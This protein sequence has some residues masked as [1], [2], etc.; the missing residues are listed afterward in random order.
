MCKLLICAAVAITLLLS[1]RVVSAQDP[2]PGTGT[3]TGSATT[4]DT[5]DTLDCSN[6]PCEVT[7]PRRSVYQ[8]GTNCTDSCDQTICN[9]TLVCGCYC[10]GNFRKINGACVRSAAC[11]KKALTTLINTSSGGVLGGGLGNRPGLGGGLGNRPGLGGGR[12]KNVAAMLQQIMA[13][14]EANNAKN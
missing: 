9:T 13:Q 14:L 12:R 7:C 4:E 3:D 8:A 10:Q 2:P 1:L 6:K 11:P 5:G